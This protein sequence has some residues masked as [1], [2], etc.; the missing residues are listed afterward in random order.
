MIMLHMNSRGTTFEY[1][2]TPD[3]T[4]FS[5]CFLAV[6]QETNRLGRATKNI[7][8]VVQGQM[9]VAS[10]DRALLEHILEYMKYLKLI[11]LNCGC[12]VK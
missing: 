4:T 6:N 5:F 8:L 3:L 12:E 11:I 9:L 2:R 1:Q 10:G 7:F